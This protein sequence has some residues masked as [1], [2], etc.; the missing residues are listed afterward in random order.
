MKKK[1][2]MLLIFL[3]IIVFFTVN[4]I[5]SRPTINNGAKEKTL[6]FFEKL[7][8]PDF[9]IDETAKVYTLEEDDNN[10]ATYSTRDIL[11]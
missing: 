6:N 4:S 11:K 8:D 10:I 2:S 1:I 7:F 9:S 3:L 5:A